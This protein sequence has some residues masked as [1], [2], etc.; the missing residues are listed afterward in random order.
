M[1]D[2][3]EATVD[4]PTVP[5]AV[6][7]AVDRRYRVPVEATDERDSAEPVDTAGWNAFAASSYPELDM[8]ADQPVEEKPPR[9]LGRHSRAVSREHVPLS[10]RIGRTMTA[11]TGTAR[12]A[13]SG[14]MARARQGI[15]RIASTGP[16]NRL[17]AGIAGIGLIFV[18]ALLVGRG[19]PHPATPTAAKPAPATS[20]PQQHQSVPPQPSAAT[21]TSV[22]PAPSQVQ[23]YGAGNT[24][25][26]VI[27][28]R[29]GVGAAYS[30]VVFDLGAAS[31]SAVGT[32]KVTV[33]FT[34]PTTM[35][36]TFNGTVPAG[37]TG[38]PTPGKVISSV[39][40]VSSSGGKTVYRFGL[41]RAAT[42]TAFY[43]ASPTRFVLDLH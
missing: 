8:Q 10:T 18:I 4:V 3:P 5:P 42:T 2:A 40:L 30:R 32:P 20:A 24:G 11:A 25:F 15:G 22:A 23:T 41:T 35:L 38:S 26:Q 14:A 13:T 7:A 19:S 12:A 43:L 31:G 21:G 1:E 16:D 6:D 36:V 9:P 29:Y 34:N 27:R 33:S 28:L 17:L 37:S 39:S